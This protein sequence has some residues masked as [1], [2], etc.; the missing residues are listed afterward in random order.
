MMGAQ[1]SRSSSLVGVHAPAVTLACRHDAE[2]LIGRLLEA[3]VATGEGDQAQYYRLVQGPN[4]LLVSRFVHVGRSST[5]LALEERLANVPAELRREVGTGAA[6]PIRV[7][8]AETSTF[9]EQSALIPDALFRGGRLR[10]WLEDEPEAGDFARLVIADQGQLAGIVR[11]FRSPGAPPFSSTIR[12]RLA[13]HVDALRSAV[14]ALARADAL[15]PNCAGALL[16]RADGELEF[17]SPAGRQYLEFGDFATSLREH[18]R[19]LAAHPDSTPVMV[20][21]SVAAARLIRLEGEPGFRYL[22]H[23]WPLVPC[24]VSPTVSLTVAERE[25]AE[26]A[27]AGA[28]LREIARLRGAALGTVKNQ[29]KQVYARLGVSSR[30]ELAHVLDVGAS[31]KPPSSALL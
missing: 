28:N 30:V 16:V 13:S 7:H 19:G 29:L 6:D 23:L 25:V 4:G 12:R 11:L 17:A 31:T 27:A 15:G 8:A 24:S 2:A 18:V 20:L 1:Q 26:L 9:V 5:R 10:R 21:D 14:V 22:V 3:L